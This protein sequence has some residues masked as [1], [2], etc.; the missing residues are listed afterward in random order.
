[1]SLDDEFFVNLPWKEGGRTLSGGV[2]CVGLAWLWLRENCPGFHGD[3][4][5]S[6]KSVDLEA[7]L[8]GRF[9]KDEM[10]RGD[11][12]F[13]REKKSGKILH[14]GIWLGEN[15]LLHILYGG[16]SRIEN[17]FKLCERVGLTA[18]G[19]VSSS[20]VELIGAALADKNLG[21][22]PVVI[23]IALSLLLSVASS[24][25]MSTASGFRNKFGQ[26]GPNALITQKNP[27][28]PLPDMLGRVV[29]AG[30]SV[31]QQLADRN[32][33]TTAAN[34]VWN[35]V[36]VLGS[37]PVNLID[38]LTGL[39]INGTTFQDSSFYSGSNVIGLFVNPTQ[40]QANAV[41][42]T[43]Y[44]NSNV[45]SVT[46]YNG[47]HD[48]SVPVD[49]RASWDRNFPVYGMSG[50]AYLAFRLFDSSKFSGFNLSCFVKGR[51]CR[52]YNSS[53]FITAT[54]TSEA[55]GTGD[56]TTVRFKLANWDSQ[57]LTSLT[58]GGATYTPISAT[59]QSGNVFQLNLTKGFVE[60]TTAPAAAAA[61]VATYNYYVRAWTQNPA[62]HL[63]YLL[64]ENG[65][66]KGFPGDRI[67]WADFVAAQTYYNATVTWADAYGTFTGARYVTNYSLDD[68]KSIQ[69]HM[70]AILDG[71][72]SSLFLSGGLFV[73]RPRQAAGGG[74][75]V[76]SFDSTNLVVESSGDS[77]F[78]AELMDRAT[79]PNRIKI[80]YH[81]D[82]AYQAESE[83]DS[84]DEDNQLQ[85]AARVGNQGVVEQQLKLPAVTNLQQA[86]RLAETFVAEQTGSVWI[87]TWKTTI[88]GLA[89]QPGD[90]VNVTH[91]S[92]PATMMVRIETIDH[93]D[94]DRLLF[95][96]SQYAAQAYF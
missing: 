57:S 16:T 69:D 68:R 86:E 71:C 91:P 38:Y 18:I 20:N 11:V 4:P 58:V 46:L 24:F 28:I 70:Q 30:N 50:C 51:N 59:N 84:D 85:R 9:K 2:D 63:V 76:F 13:F 87:L 92:L 17:G 80:F 55:V 81:D 26:Y 53:G 44:S 77:S 6:D 82:N 64:T 43:I 62:D 48:I 42:G 5:K 37:G 39:Q 65:R 74:D 49:V 95:T 89:L 67:S 15:R 34:A 10:M 56:G 27:E 96:G 72:N 21:G 61:I 66:G 7:L 60:F 31:Y 79:K 25:L 19:A 73:L 45:P 32:A 75:P 33:N 23:G 78:V 88:K 90:L 8:Q 1:M 35:Q 36:V 83:T 93:D 3:C 40:D 52:T 47:H 41:T 12:V 22:W 29:R 94:Q 54:A 14:V